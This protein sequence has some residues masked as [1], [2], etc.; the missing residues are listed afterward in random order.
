MQAVSSTE[1][2]SKSVCI[3]HQTQIQTN[4]DTDPVLDTMK[5]QMCHVCKTHVAF[6]KTYKKLS[7]LTIFFFQN[8]Q[9]FLKTQNFFEACNFSSKLTIFFQNLQIFSKAYKIFAELTNFFHNSQ[10][11]FKTYK[12]CKTHLFKPHKKFSQ[13]I[14]QMATLEDFRECQ[15]Q[16]V[17]VYFAREENSITQFLCLS[18]YICGELSMWS[19]IIMCHRLS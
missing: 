17:Y 1:S 12:V 11:F 8:L 9:N 15:N 4:L 3:Q 16:L 5:W 6:F 18:D 7:K 14:H 10:T 2:A 13:H 19:F